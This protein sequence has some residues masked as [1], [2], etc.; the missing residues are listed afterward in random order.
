MS[1]DL[2]DFDDDD[3]EGSAIGLATAYEENA[4]AIDSLRAALDEL[5]TTRVRGFAL[6]VAFDDDT[7]HADYGGDLDTVIAQ[8]R[9]LE[10]V[11]L[12]EACS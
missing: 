6:V 12:E 5:D 2:V 3:D 8:L 1:N 9:R 10:Y 11:V 4:Q 7:E